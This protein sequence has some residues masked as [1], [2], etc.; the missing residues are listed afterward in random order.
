M[1]DKIV[2]I[3]KYILTNNDYLHIEDE[4]CLPLN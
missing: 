1:V 4:G 3:L 2:E